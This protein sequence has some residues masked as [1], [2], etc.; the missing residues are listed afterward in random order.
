MSVSTMG[1]NAEI[2]IPNGWAGQ[3]DTQPSLDSNRPLT[4]A[5]ITAALQTIDHDIEQLLALRASLD[6]T[7]G[8][9]TLTDSTDVTD[10]TGK[11]L[12]ASEKNASMEG[13]LANKIEASKHIEVSGGRPN[14]DHTH[15]PILYIWTRNNLG[16][17]NVI[18]GIK[19]LSAWSGKGLFYTN[20]IPEQ[21]FETNVYTQAGRF[22]ILRFLKSGSVELTVESDMLENEIDYV[23]AQL[24]FYTN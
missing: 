1:T 18:T 6:G 23:R 17:L 9:V 8:L 21:T 14:R 16:F 13:T 10:S 2:P 11:A 24:S 19:G 15:N 7:A 3:I 4:N 20:I 12:P 22:A 5:A